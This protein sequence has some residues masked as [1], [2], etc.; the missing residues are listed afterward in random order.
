MRADLT[1]HGHPSPFRKIAKVTVF[2][3]RTGGVG[4]ESFMSNVVDVI[5]QLSPN[6]FYSNSIFT[7]KFPALEKI[8]HKYLSGEF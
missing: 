3:K 6:H 1:G 7:N 2:I 4:K 8:L 5:Y